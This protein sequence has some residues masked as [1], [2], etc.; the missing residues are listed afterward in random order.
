MKKLCCLC[1]IVFAIGFADVR[2]QDEKPWA[3]SAEAVQKFSRRNKFNYDETKVPAYTLPNPL[4][5]NDET[6]VTSAEQW[7]AL[8]RDEILNLFRDQVYGR[9]PQTKY[10]LKF[11]QTADVKDALQG[12]A[13]G[14]SMTATVSIGE[15]SY[16]WPFVLFLPNT[17]KKP[18]PAIILI[19]NR[20]FIPLEKAATEHDPFWSVE[21][22]IDRGYVT[23]SFHTSQ[24][25]TRLDFASR[26]SPTTVMC[27]ARTGLVR[28][29]LRAISAT[30]TW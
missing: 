1:G 4:I 18:V 7:N 21:Q 27:A 15:R 11:E 17:A 19:N 29:T 12:R 23:A 6:A 26:I 14:R 22:M 13:T 3:P 8:R 5:A 30:L 10:E 16:S 9:R 20:Y 24:G 28:A 25:T 2:A